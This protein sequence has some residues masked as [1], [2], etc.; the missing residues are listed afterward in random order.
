MPIQNRPASTDTAPYT[1]EHST[2]AG[3]AARLTVDLDALQANYRA[4]DAATAARTGAVVKAN[5][6]GSGMGRICSTLREV[7][8]D[9]FFIALASEAVAA[10]NACPD[11]HIYVLSPVISVDQHILIKHRLIPCLYCL[12][13]MDRWIAACAQAGHAAR[14]ALHME[15]GIHR[16]GMSPEQVKILAADAHRRQHCE[17]TLIMGHMACGDTLAN[18]QPT[19]NDTQALQ[20]PTPAE[21][22]EQNARQ[23]A[24]FSALR[25]LFPQVPASLCNSA[26]ARLGP[27]YHFDLIRAGISLFGHDP[28]Y[29]HLP[30]WCEPVLSLEAIVAQVHDAAAGERVGYAG[31][32]LC[33][34]DTR[35]AVVL[36]GYADGIPWALGRAGNGAVLAS[37]SGEDT[38]YHAWINGHRAPLVGRVSMDMVTLDIT[39]LPVDAVN[40]GDWVELFGHHVPIEHMAQCAGT[41]PYEIIT[42]TGARITRIFKQRPP[43]NGP[44]S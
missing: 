35:L 22:S 12:D 34:R 19:S 11:A 36:A 30:V 1:G 20:S 42:Q 39:D 8:C 40:A 15:T 16:A 7:G 27:D 26:T 3:A 38:R 41:V 2:N 31:T 25:G 13:E 23:L 28:H 14:A 6:Y 9:T 24:R 10:R 43:N 33:Q 37:P 5:A 17:L 44:Q 21:Q 4:I 18:M 29:R 32:F